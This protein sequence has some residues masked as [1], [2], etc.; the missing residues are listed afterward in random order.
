MPVAGPVTRATV[1]CD[2]NLASLSIE[3]SY[4]EVF[5]ES[6]GG[7]IMINA[8]QIIWLNGTLRWIWTGV[9][10]FASARTSS[11]RLIRCD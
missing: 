9:E 1:F 11:V 8:Q 5:T 2:P 6:Y 3:G 4:S 7:L 10:R